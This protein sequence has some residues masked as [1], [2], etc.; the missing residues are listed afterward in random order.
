[1][2]DPINPAPPVTRI[3]IATGTRD[4]PNRSSTGK[5]KF[6]SLRR[7]VLTKR[8]ENRYIVFLKFSVLIEFPT[9]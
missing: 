7:K 3:F 2:C 9:K 1:M 5:R 8:T 4:Y 6:S